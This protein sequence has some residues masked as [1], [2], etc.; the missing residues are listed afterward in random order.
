MWLKFAGI[1][2]SKTFAQAIIGA[3][4]VGTPFAEVQWFHALGIGATAAIISLLT[5]IAGIPEKKA[6]AAINEMEDMLVAKN[7][8]ELNNSKLQ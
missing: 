4:A 1:R 3:V 6:Y 2:A 8:T 7:T 5:S